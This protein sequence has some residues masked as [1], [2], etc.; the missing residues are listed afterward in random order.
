MPAPTEE[1][2]RRWLAQFH[3][4]EAEVDP[5]NDPRNPEDDAHSDRMESDRRA[6]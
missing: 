6:R 2:G 4:C 5:D 1:F 3:W